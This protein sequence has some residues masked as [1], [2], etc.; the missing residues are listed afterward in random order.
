VP[1]FPSNTELATA[2]LR[3]PGAVRLMLR[4]ELDMNGVLDAERAVETA[5]GI[6]ES[7]LVIDLDG[8]AFMD[9]FGARALL[10]AANHALAAGNDVVIVNPNR[11]VRRLFELITDL[12]RGRD[13][14]AP[15]VR[16]AAQAGAGAGDGP[17]G[18]GGGGSG[19]ASSSGSAASRDRRYSAYS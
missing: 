1:A 14:V 2:I 13:L 5:A 3:E 18:S 17:A 8:L 9:L 10:R 16:A 19:G 15:L 6:D 11:H 7:R 12:P 4:G